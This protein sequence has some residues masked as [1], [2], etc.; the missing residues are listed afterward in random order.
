VPADRQRLLPWS[1]AIIGMFEPERTPAMEA[2]AVTAAGEFAGFV[3]DL[4]AA[5]RRGAPTT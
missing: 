2:A 1:K 3:R 4:M 5:K